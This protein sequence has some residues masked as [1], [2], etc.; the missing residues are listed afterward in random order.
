M[1]KVTIT[2]NGRKVRASP[3]QT[4]LEV[5]QAVGIDIPT[6]C[7]EEGLEPFA[8]CWICVVEVGDNRQLLPA[9]A[10]RVT[11]GTKIQT[12]SDLVHTTRQLC[13]ELLLSDHYGDCL[14][15]CTLA[16]P[17]GCDIQRYVNFIA[18][19][20]YLEAARAIREDVPLPM[21]IG[22]ICPHP[23]E[24]AC[25]RQIKDEPVAICLLK[26]FVSDF[27]CD[28]GQV[29]LPEP[30]GDTGKR[31]AIVGAGPAGLAAAYYLRLQGHQPT[32]FEAHKQA[33]G[34]LYYGIPDYRLPKKVLGQEIDYLLS[35]GIELHMEKRVDNLQTLR[36]DGF[37]AIFLAVGAQK[38]MRLGLPGED[39]KGVLTA[40]DL[41]ESIAK[42]ERVKVG[43][44]VIVVGGGDTAIDAACSALRLGP[45]K[46]T[47]LYRRTHAEMPAHPGEITQA[48]EEGIEFH[49]LA[50]PARIIRRRGKLIAL[51]CIRMELG[52]PDASGRRRPLPIPKSEFTLPCNTLIPAI[53]QTTDLQFIPP[54]LQISKDKRGN[55]MVD[56]DT[57]ETGVR[58]VFAGGDVTTGAATAV[59]ALAAGKRAALMIDRYLKG[60]PLDK[61]EKPF[62]S[63]K[64]SLEE[65]PPEEY[66]HIQKARRRRAPSLAPE[67]RIKGFPEIEAGYSRRQAEAEAERCLACGCAVSSNCTVRQ[68]ATEYGIDTERL[69]GEKRPHPID[70]AHPLIVRDPGRCILCGRCIR[71]CDQIRGIG[72]LGFVGRGFNTEVKPTL[73]APLIFTDCDACGMCVASCPTG[74]LLAQLPSDLLA[75]TTI[76]R[77]PTISKE[78]VLTTCGYCGVGCALE[79][80]TSGGQVVGITSETDTPVNQ[81]RLC[82]RGRFGHVL[83][84]HKERLTKPLIRKRGK[85]RPTSWDEALETAASRLGSIRDQHG[86][87]ALGV[88]VSP[89][90]TNE[91]IYLA[92]RLA[93]EGLGTNK[94]GS[95]GGYYSLLAGAVLS[96]AFGPPISSASFDEIAH[97]DVLLVV[98]VRLSEDFLIAELKVR[99]A[100]KR[101]AKLIVIS[102]ESS[103]LDRLAQMKLSPE[104]RYLAKF[105][106]ALLKS[107]LLRKRL[108]ADWIQ[109]RTAGL[110]QLQADLRDVNIGKTLRT[111]G[112][113]RSELKQVLEILLRAERP[114]VL[115]GEEGL[116]EG[117]MAALCNLVLS[118]GEVGKP[119]TGIT[120]LKAKC[121]GQGLVDMLGSRNQSCELP[122]KLNLRALRGAVILGEDPV[123][124][125]RSARLHETLASLDFLVVQDLFL[126]ETA[127]LADVVLPAAT[128]AES[129]GTY[130]NSEGRVQ[131]VRP[132]INPLPGKENWQVLCELLEASGGE[133]H[134]RSA[135][136]I[137]EEA[138]AHSP[139]LKLV[140]LKRLI[141]SGLPWPQLLPDVDRKACFIPIRGD[142]RL[143]FTRSHSADV[144]EA[145]C[146]Q[147]LRQ[148]HVPA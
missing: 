21:S 30:K 144:L 141:E 124:S 33:G 14:A 55:L 138:V 123:G 25:R 125:S 86:G 75:Q 63:Q 105:L 120:A 22:R 101:G 107:A 98:N 64:G 72:A 52:E 96:R 12:D 148:L 9:C 68:L 146:R 127:R 129:T 71:V 34:W 49:F 93:R 2:L 100:V 130:T 27:E 10:T 145:R 8:A 44:H 92:G 13:L 142:R 24:E 134:Y 58:G 128:F 77:L 6:L 114:L 118:Y 78:K 37:D 41:L 99:E 47:V 28:T 89:R 119:G 70:R 16:C 43:R 45:E 88:L 53:G 66:A 109:K 57:L 94:V 91:E 103:R 67:E 87:G 131:R 38:S 48:M 112:V 121:N 126:T 46:V 83:I 11:E 76:N 117:G 54:N 133:A 36:D 5:A 51:E 20:K 74:A 18:G 56:A 110:E 147:I 106:T 113:S 102:P 140:G 82:V 35:L 23:C 139:H 115:F 65:I 69:A 79:L 42:D 97:A 50:S 39:T 81:R 61:V 104:K 73:G 4:I 85:L 143:T 31:V 1:K 90:Y 3:D 122:W 132:G 40:L 32:I 135:V 19:D 137:L 80:A 108:E 7:Y 111:A 29:K 62:S 60:E 26:R 136:E 84:H 95:L 17:V 59:E 15:P 116:T